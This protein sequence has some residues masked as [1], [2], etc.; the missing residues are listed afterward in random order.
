[1]KNNLKMDKNNKLKNVINS[2]KEEIK[3]RQMSVTK[4]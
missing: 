3:N 4:L 1:M 2:N